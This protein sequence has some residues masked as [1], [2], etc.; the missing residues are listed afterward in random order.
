IVLDCSVL[1]N[2]SPPRKRGRARRLGSGDAILNAAAGLFLEKGYQATSMDEIA[3]EAKVSKQTIY[4][5]FAGKEDLFADLVLANAG[6]VEEFVGLIGP[7]LDG[8]ESLEVR[9]RRLARTYLG[10][11]SRPDSLRLRRLIIGEAT[12]FPDL[13]R[14]YYDRV[15]GRVYEALAA[16]FRQT[17]KVEDPTQAARDF[18]WLTVGLTLDRGMF[19]TL[20][21]AATSSELDRLAGSA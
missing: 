7:A 16:A 13:A 12:R 10:F 21:G 3:A 1:Q 20:E 5:H 9:L 15:P 4:T 14:E 19:H 6:R 2:S 11:I 8:V 18:A 17:L